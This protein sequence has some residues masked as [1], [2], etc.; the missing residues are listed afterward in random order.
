MSNSP[1]FSFPL[2]TPTQAGKEIT[3]NQFVLAI[4]A[5]LK[6]A[7][8]DGSASSLTLAE[9]Q[10]L[11]LSQAQ[12]GALVAAELAKLPNPLTLAEL[13]TALAGVSSGITLAQ[14]QAELAKL[15]TSSGG[16][17]TLAQL[18]TELANLPAS[19]GGGI[20]LAQL[21]AELNA[22]PV[23][24]TVADIQAAVSGISSGGGSGGI[25]LAQLQAEIAKLTPAAFASNY[26]KL[27]VLNNTQTG[28]AAGAFPSVVYAAATGK[29]YYLDNARGLVEYDLATQSLTASAPPLSPPGYKT[30]APSLS[31][32]PSG[33]LLWAGATQNSS[34]ASKACYTFDPA[35]SSNKWSLSFNSIVAQPGAASFTAKAGAL[36]VLV[37][38]AVNSLFAQIYDESTGS[39]T[40]CDSYL[41]PS[42]FTVDGQSYSGASGV[43][44]CNL[45]SGIG[46]AVIPLSSA[47]NS[48]GTALKLVV[49]TNGTPAT[50]VDWGVVTATPTAQR[51]PANS[52][53]M[54]LAGTSYG[55]VALVRAGGTG[56][57]RFYKYIEAQDAWF[58]MAEGLGTLSAPA[59]AIAM[60]TG[61]ND[62][63]LIVAE[64]GSNPGLYLLNAAA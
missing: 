47:A 50:N 13:N 43:K 23:P 48:A 28:V 6:A 35:A 27:G 15:P 3:Y 63:V 31:V 22:R 19:Q 55:A 62:Q 61:P 24:A 25:T 54:A 17:L 40:L 64:S 37:G 46:L 12:L 42:S 33:K 21:Q 10:S 18:Q 60:A 41:F 49:N 11:F 8:I 34:T 32:L 30:S 36:T 29:F 14:L 5:L 20:T 44:A 51:F 26:T 58:A 59:N 56:L 57:T 4:D 2:M 1:N 45:P 53:C 16:C 9:L 7:G 38:G 39:F 52:C